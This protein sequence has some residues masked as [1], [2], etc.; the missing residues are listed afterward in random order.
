MTEVQRIVMVTLMLSLSSFGIRGLDTARSV[1]ADVGDASAVIADFDRPFSYSYLAFEKQSAVAEGVA[2]IVGKTS[3]GGVGVQ[4][5]MDLSR[6]ADCTPVIWARIGPANE[7]R[8]IK[9]FFASGDA[10]RTFAYGLDDVGTREF[11]RVL[12]Q[13]S[14]AL[15]GPADDEAGPSF[16]SAHIEVFQIQGDWSDRAVDVFVDKIE[17]VPPTEEMMAR[18]RARAEALRRQAERKQR[19][20]QRR[21]E[22][23]AKL[24]AGAPHP[25]DGPEVR[26][27]AA[28]DRRTIALTIE[29]GEIS[30]RKQI[31]YVAQA[32]DEIRAG[33]K[34]DDKTLLSWENGKIVDA[35]KGRFVLRDIEGKK[36]LEELGPLVVNHGL[37][38]PGPACHGAAMTTETIDQ[39]RAYRITSKE[40]PAF[41]DG[42][43]P[44]AV[45][46]K[47]K[48]TGQADGKI[49]VRFHV[50]LRLHAPL[51]DGAQYT[52]TLTGINTRR[53][54][55]AYRHD[56][57]HVRSEAVHVTQIGFR[58]SDP[59][60]RAYLSLWIGTGGAVAYGV[61]RFELLEAATDKTVYRGAVRL[62]FPADRKESIRGGKNYTQTNVYYL[63]FHDFRRPGTYR[64]FV[65][66]VGV[67][68]PF[69]IADDVW[70][71]AFALSMH[72]FLS[73]RSGIALGPP[74]TEYVRPRPMHPADGFTV[75]DL[76]VTFWTGEADAV[77]HSLR[78][79][80]GPKRDASKVTTYP[81]AWGGYMDAGD[82]DRRSQHLSATWTHLELLDLFGDY[83]SKFKLALPA[84]EARDE[85]PD[86]LNEALWNL[87]FYRRLQRP[88][89]GIGGG[90]E[91]TSHPVPGEASWQESLLAGTFAPDP[92]TSLRYAACAATAAR[93][94]ERYD[95]DAATE[96]AASARRAWEWA[97]ANT[98][99]AIEAE[100]KTP[101]SRGGR[102]PDKLREAVRN[103]RALAAVALY[104]LTGQAEYHE[105]F[106]ESS[107]LTR[108]GDD[109]GKQLHS[110]FAYARLPQRDADADLQRAAVR[111]FEQ[112]AADSL[113]FAR[114]NAFGVT[115]RVAMLPLIGYVGYYSVPETS[116]GAV[117]PRAHYLTRK[118]EYLRGAVAAAQFSAGANPMNMTFTTGLGHQFPQHPLH[119]DSQHAGIEPPDGI[120][121]YGIND[122]AQTGGHL[123][124]AHTWFLR[125]A[126]VPGSRTWPAGEFYVDLGNWPPMNEYTVHQ[127]FAP[128]S[129]YWGYLAARAAE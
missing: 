37:L 116:I 66:G 53:K 80:L 105:A 122:P 54:A 20:A 125:N 98:A 41:A 124:W 81:G 70:E 126:M 29:A 88:S 11:V 17:L 128:T 5:E 49:P 38:A 61:E 31:S 14:P 129:F 84:E 72:G 89:G 46:I 2:H 93:L 76:D 65:P 56:P 52:I 27:V 1:R 40:D 90:V 85:L 64:I 15:S 102:N 32:G 57:R 119:V 103:M 104:R 91:S 112:A 86:I 21:R 77:H 30:L 73:H 18:R 47:S 8:Q 101:Q 26:H 110:V 55:V 7:A 58:P 28:A 13:H 6:Y 44:T 60:K 99:R 94:I 25:D 50:Y 95:A 62:G 19:E 3:K 63:D 35:P 16:D 109:P 120:T 79:L 108:A 42:R 117:L 12:P 78:R 22:Q 111:W 97:Q 123:D 115:C 82:W 96:Y 106:K 24:L 45:F 33:K 100:S 68:Y 9:V 113:K 83:F 114:G 75:F 107:A 127:T 59:Y 121:V 87:E 23:V 92:E 48:P 4:Q 34:G 69:E 39:P 71:R 67:S 118:E 43:E 36:K 10:R 51:K 74:F